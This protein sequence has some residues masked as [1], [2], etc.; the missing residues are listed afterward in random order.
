MNNV[1]TPISGLYSPGSIYIDEKN[2]QLRYRISHD[3]PSNWL[4]PLSVYTA[5]RNNS[6]SVAYIKRGQPVSVGYFDDLDD[7][8][9][10]EADSAI[11]I[12]D[13][14]S[15][16]TCIGIAL[17]AGNSK[18]TNNRISKKVHVLS[19]GQIEYDLTDNRDNLF[20]PPFTG[21]G[22]SRKYVWN[23][24]NDIGK[25]VYITI[26]PTAVRPGE[27]N[28]LTTDITKAYHNGSSIICVGKIADAPRENDS[29]DQQQIVIEVQIS[30][31]VRGVVDSTQF[32]IVLSNNQIT[33][34][35]FPISSDKLIFVKVKQFTRTVDGETVSEPVGYVIET[36]QDILA[37][38]AQHSPFGAFKVT[39]SEFANFNTLFVGKSILCNRLGIIEGNFNNNPSDF[40]KELFLVDGNT[41]TSGAADTYEYKVGL[42]LDQRRILIDC[43]YPRLFTRFDMIGTMRPAYSD[44]DEV[45]TRII[46]DPGFVKMT[47]G[48]THK[49]N[50]AWADDEEYPA[51]DFSTLLKTTM[52]A[53]FYEYCPPVPGTPPTAPTPT[54]PRW[55][56]ITGNYTFNEVAPDPI[57]SWAGNIFL[58]YFRFKDFYY[59]ATNGKVVTQ[60]KY[61]Q[62]G[63]PE[64][65]SYIWPEVSFDYEWPA[66]SMTAGSFDDMDTFNLIRDSN[67][68]ISSHEFDITPIVE[69]GYYQNGNEQ[70]IENYDIVLKLRDKATNKDIIMPAGFFS[71]EDNLYGFQWTIYKN[72]NNKWI[73]GMFCRPNQDIIAQKCL[74]L[75]WPIGKRNTNPILMNIV[76]RRRPIQYHNLMLNQLVRQNP[77]N[78]FSDG[79]NI[80]TKNSIY[81]GDKVPIQT[82]DDNK[83]QWHSVGEGAS[84]LRVEN[85]VP[86]TIDGETTYW[87]KVS[88]IY[89]EHLISGSPV[90][91]K[92]IDL[93]EKTIVPKKVDIHSTNNPITWTYDFKN[94]VADLSATMAIDA[95][96]R[97]TSEDLTIGTG[98]TAETKQYINSLED[99]TDDR[100]ALRTLY[101]VPIGFFRYENAL[102]D[103]IGTAQEQWD[104]VPGSTNRFRGPA[105]RRDIFPRPVKIEKDDDGNIVSETFDESI[106]GINYDY[107][108]PTTGGMPNEEW[109]K[110]SEEI[111]K[112]F[113][114]IIRND[115]TKIIGGGDSMIFQNNIAILNRAAKETQDR[116]LKLERSIFGIDCPS[117]P[118]NTRR[119]DST[120]TTPERE[121]DI[122]ASCLNEGGLLRINKVLFDNF[123]IRDR[124][125][126]DGVAE[127]QEHYSPLMKMFYDLFGTYETQKQ[128]N[129]FWYV[130]TGAENW[131]LL[132]NN[133]ELWVKKEITYDY[134]FNNIDEDKCKFHDVFLTI[135]PLAA[136]RS[137]MMNG[138]YLFHQTFDGTPV[139]NNLSY[140]PFNE[141]TNGILSAA[142]VYLEKSVDRNSPNGLLVDLESGVYSWPI[143]NEGCIDYEYNFN[144]NRWWKSNLVGINGD[145]KFVSQSLEGIIYDI[146]T[147]LTYLRENSDIKSQS[148]NSYF[149]YISKIN[150]VQIIDGTESS[151]PPEKIFISRDTPELMFL[152]N[153]FIY[154][155]DHSFFEHNQSS[156]IYNGYYNAFGFNRDK[157]Q[158]A[159]SMQ[160][161]PNYEPDNNTN[162][163]RGYS[164]Y[165]YITNGFEF[166]SNFDISIEDYILY[167][168]RDI[169]DYF[170]TIYGPNQVNTRCGH[171]YKT[172]DDFLSDNFFR[173]KYM[174][175]GQMSFD[176]RMFKDSSLLGKPTDPDEQVFDGERD[177][178]KTMHANL[179]KI[180]N[181]FQSFNYDN[182]HPGISGIY[183][184]NLNFGKLAVP[185]NENISGLT[186]IGEPINTFNRWLHNY[187]DSGT[188]QI[189]LKQNQLRMVDIELSEE[190]MHPV[191]NED[192]IPAEI[193]NYELPDVIIPEYIISGFFYE[194]ENEDGTKIEDISGYRIEEPVVTIPQQLINGSET[195]ICEKTSE[196]RKLIELPPYEILDMIFDKNGIVLENP[197]FNR[198]NLP[199]PN[200]VIPQQTIKN[201]YDDDN[202]PISGDFNIRLPLP[203]VVLS[204]EVVSITI[205]NKTYTITTESRIIPI[206]I[207]AEITSANLSPISSDTINENTRTYNPPVTIPPTLDD[208]GDPIPGTG[209]TTPA[210]MTPVNSWTANIIIPPY[211]ATINILGSTRTITVPTRT[212]SNVLITRGQSLNIPGYT[213]PSINIAAFTISEITTLERNITLNIPDILATVVVTDGTGTS[214]AG[215]AGTI[216]INISNNTVNNILLPLQIGSHTSLGDTYSGTITF[217]DI[218]VQPLSGQTGLYIENPEIDIASQTLSGWSNTNTSGYRIENPYINVPGQIIHPQEG[219]DA[220]IIIPENVISGVELVDLPF[221][222]LT[223]YKRTIKGEFIDIPIPDYT[224]ENIFEQTTVT[225]E[226]ALWDNN[227]LHSP[228]RLDLTFNSGILENINS[229]SQGDSIVDVSDS[230]RIT[231]GL[232]RVNDVNIRKD[233]SNMKWNIKEIRQTWSNVPIDRRGDFEDDFD[234]EYMIEPPYGESNDYWEWDPELEIHHYIGPENDNFED[235]DPDDPESSMGLDSA[236]IE[237][238]TATFT[239]NSE[240]NNSRNIIGFRPMIRDFRL[241]GANMPEEYDTYTKLDTK[242]HITNNIHLTLNKDPA[243]YAKEEENFKSHYNTSISNI[244]FSDGILLRWEPVNVSAYKI[245]ILRYITDTDSNEVLKSNMFITNTYYNALLIRNISLSTNTDPRIPYTKMKILL[246]SNEF[247]NTITDEEFL[248]ILKGKYPFI[249]TDTEINLASAAGR[250]RYLNTTLN[251]IGDPNLF[252][253]IRK[254]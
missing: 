227:I 115:S 53:G 202:I 143:H 119:R 200:L 203:A 125:I 184:N 179:Y 167:I 162:P 96:A 181:N 243:I 251:S 113:T 201:E 224:L 231:S 37:D 21:S 61:T 38:G 133:P 221:P 48:V 12:T 182:N 95:N 225:H 253:N 223:I 129:D 128:Y 11:V 94:N 104:E 219:H 66:R 52:Y 226:G 207:P 244:E 235:I 80:I 238:S 210:S 7:E 109:N 185:I 55:T 28:G 77:W 17:E 183:S 24:E 58:G 123:I 34:N 160:I 171:L 108:H 198:I 62:E 218:T 175:L 63:A 213:T 169:I 147:K 5:G 65:M 168:N 72:L 195:I 148:L 191:L 69:L 27:I 155:G 180:T 29:S 116:L 56:D 239:N 30:G 19:H 49:V 141:N 15:Y 199:L 102:R 151:L 71:F 172:K 136:Q 126:V 83:E 54:D 237:I 22:S 36:D 79:Q 205:P 124:K 192:Y 101:E 110:L 186:S 6:A 39:P 31:D 236:R 138:D 120:D 81:F 86:V 40:G 25:L 230:T 41:V 13:P 87:K 140:L 26:D 204:G 153:D 216:E 194:K 99:Y 78:A 60:I 114:P 70:N 212:I 229:E 249:L 103:S 242:K 91:K 121:F 252:N 88:E 3:K 246:A 50:G 188:L 149:T 232:I 234:E 135:G 106:S 14:R 2:D 189:G 150:N 154:G 217:N 165:Q 9:Q 137:V 89:G 51:I 158:S 127:P 97:K 130:N 215:Q 247:N 23:Y 74:G 57:G 250:R 142:K 152:K 248:E 245:I 43:R 164:P 10:N 92:Q 32:E 45:P 144:E 178:N 161:S 209:G 163:T 93:L 134:F 166:T 1:E 156:L 82:E 214:S 90:T 33:T 8:T 59:Q 174:S 107:L 173:Y 187:V 254:I 20:H 68:V 159:W 67:N 132:L 122:Y 35:Q 73:L 208:D 170:S 4:I 85:Q 76:V 112:I 145:N 111:D 16:K 190:I 222:D 64:T 47:P 100:S 75:T 46:T 139:Q 105:T 84:E 206:I 241:T 98:P 176:N 240:D 157:I 228:H 18:D 42:V 233:E 196:E 177:I 44:I 118:E 197:D 146:I 193:R 211:S 220:S 131:E 117:L